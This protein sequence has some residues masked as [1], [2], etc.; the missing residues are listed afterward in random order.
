MYENTVLLSLPENDKLSGVGFLHQVSVKETFPCHTHDFFEFFYVLKGK[1]IHDINGQKMV[2]SQGTLVF[3]RPADVHHYSF[4]NNYDMEMISIGVECGLVQSACN[5]LGMDIQEFLKPCLPSQIIYTGG[6]HW[7]MAEKLLVIDKKSSGQERRQ[8]FL[9]ILPELL[10]QM[11]FG[12]E[13]QDKIIP[14][15]LSSLVEEMSKTE[16][17][18]EGLPKMIDLSGVS[19]EHLNRS[20]KKYLEMTPTAFINMKRIDYSAALLSEGN[21]NILDICYLCG[22]QNV[23]Y[24]Y[25]IFKETY[26]CTPKQFAKERKSI[27]NQYSGKMS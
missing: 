10:Y 15:W 7:D 25:Q 2:L 8:Y 12:R 16:N 22:F 27:Q 18:V 5:F 9:S 20:F 21:D 4:I 23:S 19:Q 3:I 26:H 6:S 13:Q 14:P 11:K 24:F 1:A 17:F